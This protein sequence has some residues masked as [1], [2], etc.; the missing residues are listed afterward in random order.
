MPKGTILVVDDSFATIT[1]VERILKNEGYK[2]ITSFDGVDGLKK[3]YIDFPDLVILDLVLPALDGFEVCRSL[4]QSEKCK[5]IPIIIVTAR[6]ELI[7]GERERIGADDYII[8]PFKEKELL[9]KV[10]KVLDKK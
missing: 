1:V 3:A 4:K 10:E 2:V 9:K 5:G 7:E 8:K 6:K